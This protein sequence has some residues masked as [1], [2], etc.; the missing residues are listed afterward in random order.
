VRTK[1]NYYLLSGVYGTEISIAFAY[2]VYGQ[3][4]TDLTDQYYIARESDITLT[5]S[6][7]N[8]DQ[9]IGSSDVTYNSANIT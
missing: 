2:K 4:N 9:K 5:P 6:I 3:N 7:A 8:R 1:D